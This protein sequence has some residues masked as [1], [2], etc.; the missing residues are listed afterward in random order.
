MIVKLSL[1]FVVTFLL[2]VGGCSYSQDYIDFSKLPRNQQTQELLKLPIDKQIDYHLNAMTREPPDRRLGENIASQGD[3]IIPDVLR[4]L[5]SEKDDYQ[6]ANV[7]EIFDEL[8]LKQNC[9][10]T[11]PELITQISEEISRSTLR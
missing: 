2:Q 9:S 3:K 11:H 1:I 4:R 5:K 8:C 10:Q 6:K 7:I